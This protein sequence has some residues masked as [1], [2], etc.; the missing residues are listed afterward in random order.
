MGIVQV[1]GTHKCLPLFSGHKIRSH[2]SFD[3]T[4][5]ISLHS[6]FLSLSFPLYI[7]IMYIHVKSFGYVTTGILS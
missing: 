2:T 6:L 1:N 7:Y 4:L 3:V 5:G